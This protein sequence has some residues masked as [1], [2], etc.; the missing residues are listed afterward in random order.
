[1]ILV[2]LRKNH[3]LTWCAATPIARISC[4]IAE[5]FMI[6]MVGTRLAKVVGA[7]HKARFF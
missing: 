3:V 7:A 5:M 1:M 2:Q 6:Y 4:L